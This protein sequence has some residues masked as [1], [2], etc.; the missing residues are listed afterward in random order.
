MPENLLYTPDQVAQSVLGALYYQSTLAR[1][2]NTDYS[3]EFTSGR[4]TVVNV[5]RPVVVDAA[6]IRTEDDFKNRTKITY[7]NL[8]ESYVPVRLSDMVYN[9]VELPDNF[10]TFT[11]E[12]LNKQV[13]GPMVETV[14]TAVNDLVANTFASVAT[15]LTAVDK[16]QRTKIVGEDGKTY[17]TIDAV[18]TAGTRPVGR[19]AGV[20]VKAEALNA[21]TNE[22]ILGAI[23]AA[24]M[25]FTERGVPTTGRYLV[26]GSA[27]AAGLLA[28]PNLNKVNEAGE[29]SLLRQGTLGTLYGFTI[30][31]DPA[32][33]PYKAYA[34]QRDAITLV[35]RVPK[36]P[37]GA[38]FFTTTAAQG[39]SVAYMHDYETDTQVD[40]AT[41]KLFAG[42]Q[43]LDAQ[44]IAVLTGSAGIE[45]PAAAAPAV[46]G[47]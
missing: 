26:V 22:G 25:L 12:D 38:S 13:I 18:A 19:G 34:F 8:G 41:V 32:I 44:R 6:R 45:A 23:R 42:A 37:L 47:S 21:T 33:D 43:I 3:K 46:A 29:D 10:A 30:V 35:T 9:A 40:R 7:S 14:A 11:L 27:W 5:K 20:T 16:A 15:G 1:L 31:E 24:R 39:F 36:Q 28:L 2:V 17:D 4:G